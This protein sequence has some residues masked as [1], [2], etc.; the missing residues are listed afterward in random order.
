MIFTVHTSP[1]PEFK[2]YVF[3]KPI[4]SDNDVWDLFDMLKEAFTRYNDPG[5]YPNFYVSCYDGYENAVAI[6]KF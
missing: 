6:R 2:N 4:D 3:I 5:D 1:L